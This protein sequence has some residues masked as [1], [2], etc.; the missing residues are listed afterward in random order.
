MQTQTAEGWRKKEQGEQSWLEQSLQGHRK[1]LCS[2]VHFG[3]KTNLPLQFIGTQFVYLLTEFGPPWSSGSVGQRPLSGIFWAR[4]ST[5]QISES[6]DFAVHF[7]TS[8]YREMTVIFLL[9]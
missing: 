8:E 6:K 5:V 7:S 2:S 3:M 1:P 4:V 9:S